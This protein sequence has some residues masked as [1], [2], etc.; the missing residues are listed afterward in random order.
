MSDYENSWLYLT[1]AAAEN[2]YIVTHG[3][4]NWPVQLVFK[5]LDEVVEYVAKNLKK[6]PNGL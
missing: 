3:C 4:G 6:V 2:G 1:L 5:S